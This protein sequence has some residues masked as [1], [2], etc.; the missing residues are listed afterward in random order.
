MLTANL[1][2]NLGPVATITLSGDVNDW[3]PAGLSTA[4]VIRVDCGG[5]T[6]TITGLVAQEDGR[7]I[8]ITTTNGSIIFSGESASSSAANRFA[9]SGSIISGLS[10]LLR[11][12][13]TLGRWVI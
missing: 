5:V 6:R 9:G 1:A 13:G 4:G 8:S 11:Y 2:L 7:M 3:N 12:D 10:R